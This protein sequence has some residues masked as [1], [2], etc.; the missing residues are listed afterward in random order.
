M[1]KRTQKEGEIGIYI[2]ICLILHKEKFEES[3]ESS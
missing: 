2:L 3:S 1:L